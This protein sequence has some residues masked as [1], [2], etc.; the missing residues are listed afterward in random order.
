MSVGRLCGVHYL[1][2]C[3]INLLYLMVDVASCFIV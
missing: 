2:C 3:L 1:H